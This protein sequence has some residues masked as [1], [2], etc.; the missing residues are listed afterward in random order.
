MNPKSQI[1]MFR[2]L[3]S[4]FAISVM[5]CSI[6]RAQFFISTTRIPIGGGITEGSII[7]NSKTM[8]NPG[9]AGLSVDLPKH[10][11][12]ELDGDGLVSRISTESTVVLVT[13]SEEEWTKEDPKAF[14]MTFENAD[15]SVFRKTTICYITIDGTP[16]FVV[17]SIYLGET[18]DD[19]GKILTKGEITR[20]EMNSPSKGV[21]VVTRG[22]EVDGKF[23]SA[24]RNTRINYREEEAHSIF[25]L[26]DEVRGGPEEEW[27]A[28]S[29]V[30]TEM[31][32]FGSQLQKIRVVEFP[33]GEALTET[34]DYYSDG[35]VTGPD[36][37]VA[38]GVRV[39]SH[40]QTDGTETTYQYIKNGS[41]EETRTPGEPVKRMTETY[42]NEPFSKTIIYEEDNKETLRITKKHPS[43]TQ[44]ITI[45]KRAGEEE[46]TLIEEVYPYGKNFG[47]QP[48]RIIEHD[49]TITTYELTELPEGGVRTVMESGRGDGE[50]VVKGTRIT[51][52]KTG[53]GSIIETKSEA[54]GGKDPE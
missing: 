52:V 39:K 8:S 47:G 51:T 19:Y 35:Q 54:I 27:R 30:L 22:T 38:S 29:D 34:W 1:V 23:L 4:V 42:V 21:G 53:R 28:T 16:R 10:L 18:M 36:G 24:S 3:F 13:P 12:T 31:K 25:R 7:Y 40:K 15:G 50:R 41:I 9:R 20:S 44:F 33:D 46:E 14:T 45:T 11:K 17:R 48:R 43:K 6:A 2:Y 49:G 26:I 32:R 5:S 37:S